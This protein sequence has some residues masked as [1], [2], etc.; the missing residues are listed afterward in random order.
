MSLIIY[1][2][3]EF[4][5][6][7]YHYLANDSEYD[8][9][10]FSADSK[11]I[12]TKKYCGLPLIPFDDIENK[13]NTKKYKIIVAVGYSDMR[14]RKKM[15]NKAK[16]KGFE[17]INYISS[18]AFVDKTLIIGE[19]NIILSN[20][21]IEPFVSIGNNNIIWTSVNICHNAKLKSHSFIASQSLLGGFS[22]L[23]NNC[24]IG[25]NSTILQ[26]ITI[27]KESVI[28]AK[29]LVLKDTNKYS[30]NFGSPSKEVS[31]HKKFGAKII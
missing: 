6:L 15:Y 28:G 2:K 14:N 26:G 17:C 31:K 23:E 4:A 1:G 29:S 12:N 10:G 3:G 8:V 13:Y 27:K 9:V 7:L 18:T 16:K 5:K 22:I 24:F 25:F 19:N 21:I 20:V 11:Y 30:K